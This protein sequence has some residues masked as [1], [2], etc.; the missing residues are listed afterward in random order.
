[1]ANLT[2]DSYLPD[3]ACGARRC[4]SAVVLGALSAV[5]FA[6]KLAVVP[7]WAAEP[8]L[9]Q[10]RNTYNISPGELGPA[11]LS[12]AGQAGVNLSIDMNATRGL[13]TQGL[14]GQHSVQ[15]GFERLLAGTG[16]RI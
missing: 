11:L 8:S 6:A 5:G 9:A 12:Y 2:S 3:P 4:I 1:M 7:V 15:S 13:K 16:L 14:T 10:T